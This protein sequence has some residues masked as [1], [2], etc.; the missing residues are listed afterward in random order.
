MRPFYAEGSKT[1]AYEVAEQLGWQAPRHTIVPGAS[2]SMFT[3]IWK[4]FNEFASLGLLNGPVQTKMHLAQAEGCSPIITAYNAGITAVRPVKPDTV[5]KSLAI[6]NPAD[7]FYAL[8]VIEESEG[9]GYAVPETQITEGIKL[10]ARTEGV[11]TETAG[12]V[13]IAALKHLAEAGT[14]KRNELTVAYI[15]GNGL[16]TLEVVEDVVSPLFVQ[17]TM[18]S[19]EEALN[20]KKTGAN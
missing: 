20:N 2:G 7:G 18:A 9:S 14:I 6:G 16:K 12:G 19:F 17:P 8:K 4:G 10:L 3:K 5:A 13:V 15:T 11:F 1:L